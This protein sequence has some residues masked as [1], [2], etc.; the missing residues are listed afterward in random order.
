MAGWKP[1]GRGS[2]IR[3]VRLGEGRAPVLSNPQR[4]GED[5][6]SEPAAY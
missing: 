3:Y 6:R 2:R 1:V 5:W 4:P